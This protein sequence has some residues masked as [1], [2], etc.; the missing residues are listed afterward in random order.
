[1]GCSPWLGGS[2]REHMPYVGSCRHSLVCLDLV[3][4][5]S[6]LLS[7]LSL[8]SPLSTYPLLYSILLYIISLLY[9]LLFPTSFITLPFLFTLSAST[10]VIRW[11]S[12]PPEILFHYPWCIAVG[13][14]RGHSSYRDVPGLAQRNHKA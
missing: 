4:F 2:N 12:H 6:P 9:P 13:T 5:F 3:F 1:M 7:S 11:G 14:E 10:G 8:P